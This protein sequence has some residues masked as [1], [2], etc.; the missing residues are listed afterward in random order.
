MIG[1]LPNVAP[2]K[3]LKLQQISVDAAGVMT[4]NHIFCNFGPLSKAPYEA[5]QAALL[6]FRRL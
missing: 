6:T 4:K 5:H 3:Y 2:A 1:L